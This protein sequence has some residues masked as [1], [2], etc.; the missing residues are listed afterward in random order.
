MVP[1]RGAGAAL[2]SYRRKNA[3]DWGLIRIRPLGM[4]AAERRKNAANGV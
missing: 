4:K 3:A 2:T 1:R